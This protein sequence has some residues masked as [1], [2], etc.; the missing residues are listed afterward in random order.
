VAADAS[1]TA[2]EIVGSLTNC[3]AIHAETTGKIVS[4]S[5]A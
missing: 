5:G 1:W 4:Y 3:E 2:K